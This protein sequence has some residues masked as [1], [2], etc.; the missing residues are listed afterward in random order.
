MMIWPCNVNTIKCGSWEG[1]PVYIL[2]GNPLL[3]VSAF[4]WQSCS[5]TACFVLLGVIW[6]HSGVVDRM[7]LFWWVTTY[8]SCIY[9]SF[10]FYPRWMLVLRSLLYWTLMIYYKVCKRELPHLVFGLFIAF[11]YWLSLVVWLLGPFICTHPI[12]LWYIFWHKYFLFFCIYPVHQ[13]K[14]SG[15]DMLGFPYL[16]R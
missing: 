16:L 11:I 8:T 14:G 4:Q 3:I 15:C 10:W 2:M 5:N 1:S 13:P 9:L 6:I 7:V 12:S